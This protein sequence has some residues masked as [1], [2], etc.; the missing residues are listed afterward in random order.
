[1][2]GDVVAYWLEMWWLW[3]IAGYVVAHCWRFGGSLLE[4]WWL[5]ARYVVAQCW[6]CGGS[7]LEM[8]HGLSVGDVVTG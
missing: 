1:M 7:L 2:G 3:L 5:T 6:V 8:W 4:M